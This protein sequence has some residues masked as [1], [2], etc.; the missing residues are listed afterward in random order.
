MI[1]VPQRRPPGSIAGCTGAQPPTGVV[2]SVVAVSL[3]RDINWFDTADPASLEVPTHQRQRLNETT[4]VTFQER[5]DD[6]DALESLRVVLLR[7][8]VSH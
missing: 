2:N 7:R 1:G 5:E 4:S 6:R 8:C 3:Q